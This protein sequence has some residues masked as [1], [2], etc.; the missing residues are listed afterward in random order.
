MKKFFNVLVLLPLLVVFSFLGCDEVYDYLNEVEG[1]QGNI[2]VRLDLKAIEDYN[3]TEIV[4]TLTPDEGQAIEHG[5]FLIDGLSF[6]HPFSL[7]AG[8]WSVKVEI[9]GPRHRLIGSGER[10]NVMVQEG[11]MSNVEITITMEEPQEPEETGIDLTV[12]WDIP[13][14][15]TR[16]KAGKID[17]SN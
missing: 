9:Y 8:K 10:N 16:D 14:Y 1:E 4:V 6:T 7:T 5:P 15:R 11:K 3:P 17:T 13:D 12:T 2:Q